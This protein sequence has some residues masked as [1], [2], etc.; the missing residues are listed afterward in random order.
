MPPWQARASSCGRHPR[1]PSRGP[2]SYVEEG[3]LNAAL[4]DVVYVAG[5]GETN[6]VT[7]AT[8][9]NDT[10]F[11]IDDT[12]PIEAGQNCTH[13]DAADLTRVTCTVE[14]TDPNLMNLDVTLGDMDDTLDARSPEEQHAE[15][16]PGNDVLD[17]TSTTTGQAAGLLG[18]PGSDTIHSHGGYDV[19]YGEDS[20]FGDG[21]ADEIHAG[22]GDDLVYGEGGD[23]VIHGDD[24]DDTL[25][26]GSGTDQIDGGPGTDD[27]VQD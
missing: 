21:Q 20:Y 17:A 14:T 7:V 18:G 24:G 8:G 25:Y 5:S 26:G 12:I 16:G 9:A 23:D 27:E 19:I 4:P 10:E 2:G 1:R 11:V 22:G 3:A 6:E 13:P 15:G